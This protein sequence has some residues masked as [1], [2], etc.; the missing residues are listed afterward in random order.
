MLIK[1]QK[2]T[3]VLAGACRIELQ[4]KVLEIF[5]LTV[6]KDLYYIK[7]YIRLLST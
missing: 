6:A 2:I 3:Y 7:K 4:S 1:Y 5:I